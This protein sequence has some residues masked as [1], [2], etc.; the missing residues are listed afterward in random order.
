LLFCQNN[1]FSDKSAIIGLDENELQYF[2]FKPQ[3]L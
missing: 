1:L 3:G 2:E